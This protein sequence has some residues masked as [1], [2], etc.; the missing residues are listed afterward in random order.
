MIV[1]DN[2]SG[3]HARI[4]EK[5]VQ[6]NVGHVSSYGNDSLTASAI[7]EIQKLFT[8]DPGVYFVLNGTAAN[9]LGLSSALHAYEGC[10]C[11]SRAHIN[12]DECGAFERFTGSKI[13]PIAHCD[14]KIS[15]KDVS[16]CLHAIDNEHE[17]QPK[18]ISI[19][20]PTE[21]GTAYSPSEI[22]AL[23]DLAHEHAMYLHVDGSR[24]SNAAVGTGKTFKEM[25]ADT[26]V[27]LL[28]FGGTKN[29]MMYGEAVVVLNKS[30]D[31]SMKF[32]RKQGMHLNSKL[33]FVSAQFLGY[34]EGELWHENAANANAMAQLMVKRIREIPGLSI[35]Y[36]VQANMVF[37]RMPKSLAQEVEKKYGFEVIDGTDVRI[38]AAFDS[39]MEDIEEFVADLKSMIA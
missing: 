36:E 15:V 8:G 37:I 26:G 33:R 22:K 34:L 27:D 31:R 13:I 29:G 19:S 35:A 24:L 1:S 14:G 21:L 9:V 25:I 11:S 16:A 5:I 2:N 7:A 4:M 28:S 18:V 10:I 12:V 32:I 23:A 17:S 39:K 3:V 38:V 30:L 20:Q 6:A